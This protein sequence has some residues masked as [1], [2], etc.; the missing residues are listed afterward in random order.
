MDMRTAP[1]GPFTPTGV[2]VMIATS[3]RT[4]DLQAGTPSG[5]NRIAEDGGFEPQTDAQFRS[6]LRRV[7]RPFPVHPPYLVVVSGPG[8]FAPAGTVRV[9]HIAALGQP[10][11]TR[12]GGVSNWLETTTVTVWTTTKSS[13]SLSYAPTS[14]N[15]RRNDSGPR[16]RF[17]EVMS[18]FSPHSRP[19][20]RHLSSSLRL[21]PRVKRSAPCR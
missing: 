1:R 13:A 3:Q 8:W 12:R 18:R 16:C 5:D 6:F 21:P 14:S 20:P 10:A 15:P 19:Q 7:R 4:S 9:N 17:S 11:G 2:A